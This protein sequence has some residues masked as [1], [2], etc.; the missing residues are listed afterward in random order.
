MGKLGKNKKLIIIIASVIIGCLV[1]YF[2]SGEYQKYLR[3]KE[4]ED[5]LQALQYKIDQIKSGDYS[6]NYSSSNTNVNPVNNVTSLFLSEFSARSDGT[7]VKAYGSIKNLLNV[8]IDE[9]IDIAFF[10]EN[11]DIIR[12]KAMSV[13][14]SGGETKYFEELIG[15]VKEGTPVPVTAELTD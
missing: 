4:I 9:I 10:D 12:V 14:L 1:L 8:P 5:R 11:G 13:K 2:G 7:F 3:K 15:L 6:S